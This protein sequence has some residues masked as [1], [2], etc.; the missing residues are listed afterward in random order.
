MQPL[1]PCFLLRPRLVKLLLLRRSGD[2]CDS[3]EGEEE[4]EQ[5]RGWEFVCYQVGSLSLSM[6]E[7]KSL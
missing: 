1:L 2:S 6:R 4:Y 3:R 7:E 5:E